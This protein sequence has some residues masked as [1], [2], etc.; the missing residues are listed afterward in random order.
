MIVSYIKALPT[1]AYKN[2]IGTQSAARGNRNLP[3]MSSNFPQKM[4]KKVLIH[5]IRLARHEKQGD[6]FNVKIYHP[7][8]TVFLLPQT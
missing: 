7:L 8:T 1:L 6:K 4:E 3:K 5:Q 2:E